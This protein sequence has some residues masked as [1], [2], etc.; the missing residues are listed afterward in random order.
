MIVST[1]VLTVVGTFITEKILAPMLEGVEVTLPE[2]TKQD[3]LELSDDQNKG[4][5]YAGIAFLIFVAIVLLLTVP[6]GSLLRNPET[7]AILPNSP[8]ISGIVPLVVFLFMVV[9]IAY[10]IGA[11]TIKSSFD[12]GKY[13]SDGVSSIASFL[14]LALF[15]A[16]FVEYFKV[17]NLSQ[18]I[19]VKGADTLNSM[20][21]TGIPLIIGVVV[22]SSIINFFIISAS[23]KWTMLAPVLVPMMALLG[24][25]PAF[26]QCI[27]RIGDAITN[28]I[29]PLGTY[30]PV[31]LGF[32]QKYKKDAGV[33]TAIAY[34][35]PFAIGF[36][37][38][39]TLLVI[40]FYLFDLPL[41]PGASIHL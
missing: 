8:L 11:K 18:F 19:A 29:T 23:A 4:L 17:T 20:N 5:K 21:F 25:S 16:Q 33:G 22:F 37:I 10:G 30:L 35:I 27:Y 3:S 28:P 26:A 41:G 1:L 15:A 6:S 39:W 7:G 34:E 24:F 32:L 2:G 38:M 12:I 14:V 13:M 31:L 9:G 40:V 36:F